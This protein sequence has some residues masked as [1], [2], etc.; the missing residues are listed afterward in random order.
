M[1]DAVVDYLP[2]PTDVAG[3][4]GGHP[5]SEEVEN[6]NPYESEPFAALAFK[7]MSDKYVGRLTFLRIYSGTLKKGSAVTVAY[8]DAQ[9][10]DFRMRTERIGR[11][12]EMH[13]N[14]RNDL[15]I[16]FAG[17]IVGVIGL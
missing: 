8:R 9:T 4:K 6:R 11:I 13:A 3:G 14:S 2:A 7:I 1:L 5:R 17:D 10:N 15:D 12:L 16:A